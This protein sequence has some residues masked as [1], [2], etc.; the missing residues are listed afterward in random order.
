MK[1]IAFHINTLDQGG[2]ERVVSNLANAFAK[3]GYEVYIATEWY[4]KN[5]YPLDERVQ[6]VSVGLK[7]ED[8]EKGRIKKALLRKQYLNHRQ[9]FSK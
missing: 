4:G 2:A 1:S 6:R 9:S 5:E 7:E 3:E 8:E